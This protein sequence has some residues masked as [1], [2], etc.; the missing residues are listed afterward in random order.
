MDAGGSDNTMELAAAAAAELAPVVS[1]RTNVSACGGRGPTLTAGVAA[2]R[3]SVLLFLHADT[4]L[5]QGFDVAVRNALCE[6][7]VL[8]TAFQFKVARDEVRLLL[9][10]SWSFFLEL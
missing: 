6:E 2:S 4:L 3:G 8:A 5:P 7:R 10:F 1:I 9:D